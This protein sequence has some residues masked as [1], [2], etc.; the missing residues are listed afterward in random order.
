MAR[1]RICQKASKTSNSTQIINLNLLLSQ[2]KEL[3]NLTRE[4]IDISKSHENAFREMTD[5]L[6]N[7][8]T[9]NLDPLEQSLV[10]NWLRKIVA[11]NHIKFAKHAYSNINFEMIMLDT[12][13]YDQP[14]GSWIQ[15]PDFTQIVSFDG[16]L[17]TLLKNK[18]VISAVVRI[19]FVPSSSFLRDNF[20]YVKDTITSQ[21]GSG[22]TCYIGRADYLSLINEQYIC[23]LFLIK[24]ELV[25]VI[26]K[27]YW[28]FKLKKEK[29][30]VSKYYE[31]IRDILDSDYV[32][33]FNNNNIDE[34]DLLL[35]ELIIL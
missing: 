23:D 8:D 9:N 12:S 29:A 2:D 30:I 35:N 11:A 24:N 6:C 28:Q 5:Y 4:V 22:I 19:L 21:V 15:H 26:E 20:S 14:S 13:L 25:C 32:V 1:L 16:R 17:A 18:G 27:P 33:H 3:L 7:I 31:M 10:R 34:V